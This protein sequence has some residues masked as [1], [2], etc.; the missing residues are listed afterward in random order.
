MAKKKTKVKKSMKPAEVQPKFSEAE[1]LFLDNVKT[2]KMVVKEIDK[3]NERI[4]KI[5]DAID[6]SKKVKGL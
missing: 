1:R 6:K 5:V 2:I 4:D 3:L